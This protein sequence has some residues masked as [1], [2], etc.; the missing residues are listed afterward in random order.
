VTLMIIGVP[1]T[2][3]VAQG[4]AQSPGGGGGADVALDRAAIEREVVAVLDA[5]MAAFNRVDVAA[6]ERTFHFPH[7]RLAGGQMTVLERPGQQDQERLRARLEAIGWHH[8]GWDRRQ[9]VHLSAEKVHV[10]THFIRYR[11]DGTV[12]ASFDSLYVLTRED[13][14]WGVK[15]RSSFAP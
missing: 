11:A 10:D 15:L 7:Y 9:I 13:G 4:A 6:W 1:V 5:Y 3:S 2:R 12:L 8:S 14:V